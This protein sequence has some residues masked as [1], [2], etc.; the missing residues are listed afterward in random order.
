MSKNLTTNS[1]TSKYF[2]LGFFVYTAAILLSSVL[3]ILELSTPFGLDAR[4]MIVPLI[5]ILFV[6]A[7]GI[8]YGIASKGSTK[9][10][11]IFGT[12]AVGTLLTFV[13]FFIVSAVAWFTVLAYAA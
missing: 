3:L 1:K 7:L 13:G 11:S 5:I 6:G 4:V 9:L 2:L 8:G 12:I 10:I